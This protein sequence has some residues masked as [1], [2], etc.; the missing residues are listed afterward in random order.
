MG[1]FSLDSV[2]RGPMGPLPVP[3]V[4]TSFHQ[5]SFPFQMGTMKNSKFLNLLNRAFFHLLFVFI[6]QASYGCEDYRKG[7]L[8]V[9][10]EVNLLFRGLLVRGLRAIVLNRGNF[11]IVSLLCHIFNCCLINYSIEVAF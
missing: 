1:H 4:T 6:G 10:Y 5:N 8:A 3:H 9:H 2:P 11:A 7:C